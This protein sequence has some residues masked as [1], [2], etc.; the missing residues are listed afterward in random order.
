MVVTLQASGFRARV[1]RPIC[2][3]SSCFGHQR[4]AGHCEARSEE[5]L[6]V[7]ASRVPGPRLA[8]GRWNGPVA[9]GARPL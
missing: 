4:G 6:G 3:G 5:P 2:S 1:A 8:A 7:A 9:R